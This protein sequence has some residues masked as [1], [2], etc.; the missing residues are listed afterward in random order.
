MTSEIPL[1][2]PL[3]IPP[4]RPVLEG[5][6][7][8]SGDPLLCPAEVGLP[9]PVLEMT[10]LSEPREDAGSL[11]DGLAEGL[12]RSVDC[13]PMG[14]EMVDLESL[15]GPVGWGLSVD[16]LFDGVESCEREGC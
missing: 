7:V 15:W 2:I 9:N 16:S 1:L 13:P 3:P 14:A 5:A 10:G 6:A 4:T 12:G 11:P 8:V